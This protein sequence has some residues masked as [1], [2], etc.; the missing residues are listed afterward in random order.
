MFFI[1]K[2]IPD[3]FWWFL[4]IAGL[5]GY[6]LSHLNLLK[7]YKFIVK[8]LSSILVAVTIFIIGM[9][10]AD[11]TWKGA[12]RELE[13]KVAQAEADSK[14]ANESIKEKVV[15]KTQIVKQRGLDN[16]QYIDRE[17][18]KHD[19]GCIIP[20]EFISAHNRAAEPP[21]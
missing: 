8:N 14:I 11:N 16:I 3:W 20:P 10:Y 17:I 2:I 5:S 12:A 9:L 6:Y 7:P 15:Y 13:A 18:T 19:T 1:F 21:K 4:L